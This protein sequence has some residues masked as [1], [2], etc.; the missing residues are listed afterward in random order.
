[1]EGVRAFEWWLSMLVWRVG[2]GIEEVRL[3]GEGEVC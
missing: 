2:R 1:M 3:R